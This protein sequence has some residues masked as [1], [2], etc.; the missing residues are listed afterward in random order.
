VARQRL[1]AAPRRQAQPKGPPGAN[2]VCPGLFFKKIKKVNI[3]QLSI[4]MNI[5][6]VVLEKTSLG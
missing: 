4:T 5:M 3:K 2:N 1:A 6:L